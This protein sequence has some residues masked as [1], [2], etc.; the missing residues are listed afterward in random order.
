MLGDGDAL[1]YVLSYWRTVSWTTFKSVLDTVSRTYRPADTVTSNLPARARRSQA[2]ETLASLGHCD[3]DYSGSS[4]RLMVAPSVLA[5][6]PAPG[7]PR[8]VLCGARGPDSAETLRQACK[9]L[10]PLVRLRITEQSSRAPAA[11]QRVEVEAPTESLLSSVAEVAGIEL[12]SVAPAWKLA[13]LCP[14]VDDFLS[15]LD[16]Q[17]TPEL[18][19]PAM[20]FDTRLLRF[21][22]RPADTGPLRLT[23]YEDQRLGRRHFRLWKGDQWADADPVWARYAVLRAA[24]VTVTRYN[25]QTRTVSVPLTAP[26][27]GLASRSLTLCSGWAAEP[28]QTSGPLTGPR[29]R[30][31]E[32]VPDDVYDVVARRLGQ[33]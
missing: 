7:L 18:G 28:I 33:A 8:A 22:S 23:R 9:R 32:S 4:L 24:G 29:H 20:D 30:R 5:R 3:V 14:T 31:Y 6:L 11:P 26:L 13:A 15:R 12:L 27:P 16:W 2:V 17:S 25:R 19:L 21:R 1:L 10:A